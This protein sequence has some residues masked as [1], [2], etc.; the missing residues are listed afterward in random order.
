MGIWIIIIVFGIISFAVSSRLKSKFKKYS[1]VPL[2]KDLSG[3]EVAQLMLADHGIHDVK[4]T[5]VQGRLTDHY[6]PMNKT[7]NLSEEVYHGR[8][9]AAA[10]VASHECGHAVQHATAYSMLEFRSAM[11]PLQNASAKILNVIM[12]VMLFGGMFLFS[13]FPYE[14]VLLTI[15]GAYGVMTL[16][17]FVTL[18]VEFDASKRALAWVQGRN[19]VDSGEYDM[20]KDAL[21]WAAMTYV[22]AAI[23]SLV[24]LLY[25]ISLFLGNRD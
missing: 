4:V 24:T 5:A 21:K 9:A 20:A 25:Y 17:S 7:V 13:A 10:A 3:A 23:G 2:R 1:Q 16:F 12:M 14:L 15:I 8:N 19:I 22:V 11:V 18:P 6:N